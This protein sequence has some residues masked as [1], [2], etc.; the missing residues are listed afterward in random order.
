MTTGFHEVRFPLRVARQRGGPRRRTDIVNLL[1]RPRKPQR[2]VARFPAATTMPAPAFAALATSTRCCRSSRRSSGQLYGFR[3]RDPI[4]FRS[5]APDAAAGSHG[6]ADRHRRRHHIGIPARQVLRRCRRR[7]RAHRRQAGR[8][9]RARCRRWP[10]GGTFRFRRR[11]RR[12]PAASAS[13]PARFPPGCGGNGRL[14]VRRAGALRRRSHRCRPDRLQCRPHSRHSAPGDRPLRNLPTGLA[15]H[16]AGQATTVCHAWRLTRRDGIVFGFTDHD[17]DLAF[18]GT[19]FRAST[20]FDASDAENGPRARRLRERR[21]GRILGRFHHRQGPEG[22][23]LRRRV[24]RGL[25]GQL[26]GARPICP[27]LHPGTRG[28]DLGRRPLRAELRS[29]ANRLEQVQGRVYARRCDAAL[30]DRRLLLR[31]PATVANAPPTSATFRRRSLPFCAV[32]FPPSR[33]RGAREAPG[34]GH[35]ASTTARKRIV[36]R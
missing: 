34:G 11:S 19:T 35:C 13:P 3:F 7:L 23:P 36:A 17:R 5:C 33:E 24:G 14:R 1:E 32:M 25:P 29:L 9:H 28:G 31:R 22:R 2:Q 18:A 12:P 15:A 10:P 20:G 6:P 8:R 26:A 27:S 4:D 21:G 30:G 16:L